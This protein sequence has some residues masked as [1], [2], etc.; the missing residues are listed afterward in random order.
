MG[1]RRLLATA[2]VFAA[3][4]TSTALAQ[5]VSPAS[6]ASPSPSS[7]TAIV[8]A[9]PRTA[10]SAARP[11]TAAVAAPSPA[12]SPAH[13]RATAPTATSRVAPRAYSRSLSSSLTRSSTSRYGSSRMR[14]AGNLPPAPP[15]PLY[16]TRSTRR[17][18]AQNTR[19]PY[20]P[21]NMGRVDK[22][23]HSVKFYPSTRGSEPAKSQESASRVKADGKPQEN[24][25][26]HP[27]E[28][29]HKREGKP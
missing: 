7:T 2:A 6:P 9:A 20:G 11:A 15:P 5:S 26:L 10:R 27:F 12:A 13:S 14:G 28:L 25:A 17:S 16:S 23:G 22:S 4:T 24:A 21:D 1:I 8:P 18:L 3:A 29:V 19:D